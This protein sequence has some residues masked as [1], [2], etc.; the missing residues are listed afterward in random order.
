MSNLLKVAMI[1]TILSLHGRGWSQRRIAREL[2]IDRE[3]VARHLKLTSADANPANAPIGSEPDEP[4]SNPANAPIGS[5]PDESASNPANAPIGS[6][7]VEHAGR[8]SECEPFRDVIVGKLELGLSAQRIY[9]DLVAES[10]FAGSYYSVRRFVGRLDAQ[11]ELPFR[12]IECGPGEE[13]QV[14]FGAGAPIVTADGKRRRTHVLRIILSYSRKGFSE[15][16][17]RQTTD[18]F[19]RCLEDAFWHFGGVPQR[20]V[21][22]NLRAAVTKA[23]WFDPEINPQVQS[24]ADY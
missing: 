14:D 22:D 5:E 15:V 3:T 11:Q 6:E 20:L 13:A 19:L 23:D 9:Q 7:T 16:V 10:D 24:F 2:G 1:E 18:D 8:A 4:A 12:R 17:F 21:L